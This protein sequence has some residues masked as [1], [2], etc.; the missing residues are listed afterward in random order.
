MRVC[1]THGQT[2]TLVTGDRVGVKMKRESA[3][4]RGP[5][6]VGTLKYIRAC[7][8]SSTASELSL[9]RKR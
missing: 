7:R 9:Q 6:R 2:L 5:R 8:E 1:E 3:R 4:I